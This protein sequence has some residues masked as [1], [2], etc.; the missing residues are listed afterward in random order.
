[1][2]RV[3]VTGAGTVN[4]LGIG[5]AAT[6]AA[7]AAGHTAIGPVALR[8]A[9]RLTVRVGAQVAWDEGRFSRDQIA[10]W[11]R[12]TQFCMVAATEAMMG[13]EAQ[14]GVSFD[15]AR[16]GAI[17]GTAA[18]GHTT[19][20]DNYRAVF[21]EGRARVPPL[22]VPRLMASAAPS[23]LSLAHGLQGPCFAVSSACA[24]S[25][26]AIGLAMQ[27]IR[28]GAADVM[29]AGGAEAM[30][31]FGGIKAWEGL[32]VLSPSTCRPFA[33]TRD[34]L[35]LGEGA[36]VLV[37]E[38]ATHAAARGARVLAEVAGFGMTADAGD[39]LSPT[40]DGPVRAM[41][42]ALAEAGLDPGDIGYINA[43]GTGTR[44]NDATE[45]QAIRAVFPAPPPVSSTKGAHGH[46]I[47]A[48]GAVEALACLMALQ[49]LLPPTV[50]HD[51]PDPAIGLDV[52]PN[53]VRKARVQAC[54]SNAFAFGGLNAVLVVRTA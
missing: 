4:P 27:M 17:I 28:A 54:L 19:I 6:L 1:M 46:L 38:E 14:A 8:D 5:V 22:T 48:A 3:V 51:A 50:N 40:V 15:P 21:A 20:E 36:A 42:A 49:G 16:A 34:G 7:M 47:G 41:R 13:A 43:H 2:R 9:D 24:S 45:A 39:L 37:L 30:V 33:A 12:A 11:D 18:G 26:H 31:T 10:R 53:V 32:R 25:N 52:I 29:L 44:L 23:H 35:V